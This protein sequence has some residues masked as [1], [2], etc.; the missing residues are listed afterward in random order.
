MAAHYRL[1]YGI[2]K[3]QFSQSLP[4]PGR[5]NSGPFHTKVGVPVV[6]ELNSDSDSEQPSVAIPKRSPN[7]A[8]RTKSYEPQSDNPSQKVDF[9]WQTPRE[10]HKS[11]LQFRHS[12]YLPSPQSK[13]NQSNFSEEYDAGSGY[14]KSTS[15]PL[16]QRQ[17]SYEYMR[18]NIAITEDVTEVYVASPRIQQ[19]QFK[20]LK[21]PV[22][23]T[24]I[25]V[26]TYFVSKAGL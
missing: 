26:C 21:P 6:Q 17:D 1:K 19:H 24:Y 7:N 2:D 14:V 13:Y 11:N 3:D 8:R 23:G 16:L 4:N 15:S 22:E 10:G 12:S 20:D 25:Y 18:H 5:D 9:R